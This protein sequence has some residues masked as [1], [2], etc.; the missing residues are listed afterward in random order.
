MQP[1]QPALY[2]RG[3]AENPPNR[4]ER[5]ALEPDPDWYDPD[6]R[7][8]ATQFFKDHSDSIINYNDSPDV[9]FDA[10][11]NPY[12]GCE[13]GCVYCYARANWRGTTPRPCSSPS[14]HSTPS[15]EKSWS[16]ARRRPPVGCRPLKRCPKRAFPLACWSRPSSRASPTTK[17]PRSSPPRSRPGRS[18]LVTSYCVCLTPLRPCSS[19]GWRGISR[20]CPPLM[21]RGSSASVNGP[22]SIP[23]QSGPFEWPGTHPRRPPLERLVA[24]R[25]PETE[26]HESRVY[27]ENVAPGPVNRSRA[28]HRGSQSEARTRVRGSDS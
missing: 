11:V 7:P 24:D 3:A 5:I 26:G 20:R 25:M 15:C 12:R 17:Y 19:N 18:S 4:F 9:G 22:I 27:D 28:G 23:V 14:P 16:R 10:S 8:L 21:S 1:V 13:H 2:A 6:E